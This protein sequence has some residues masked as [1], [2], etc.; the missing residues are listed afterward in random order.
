MLLTQPRV[1]TGSPLP[2]WITLPFARRRLRFEVV[3]QT[4]A[5]RPTTGPPDFDEAGAR[6]DPATSGCR[7]SW[8][9]R[10]GVSEV[11]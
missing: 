2:S 11:S 7:R 8:G 3:P 9:V 4:G 5:L 6:G 1:H 10:G